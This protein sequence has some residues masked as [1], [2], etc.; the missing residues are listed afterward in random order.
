MLHRSRILDIMK[1]TVG[2][3]PVPFTMKFVKVSTGEI[4]QTGDVVLTSNHSLGD[5]INV[6]FIESGQIRKVLLH[7]IIEINGEEIFW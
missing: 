6:K 7:S 1:R 3:T 5:T 2:R 4:I